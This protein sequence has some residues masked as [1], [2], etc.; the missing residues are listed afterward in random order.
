MAECG[1]TKGTHGGA[2]AVTKQQNMN[3]PNKGFAD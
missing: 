3:E 1:G 2:E